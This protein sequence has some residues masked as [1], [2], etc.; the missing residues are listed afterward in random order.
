MVSG[1][2]LPCCS[3]T[4]AVL[5]EA[6]RWSTRPTGRLDVV[7][8]WLGNEPA[9]VVHVDVGTDAS[10]WLVLQVHVPLPGLT[11]TDQPPVYAID[12]NG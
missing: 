6:S 10:P 2:A 12:L 5:I 4:G 9:L 1:A 8:L 7:G 3:S 11:A